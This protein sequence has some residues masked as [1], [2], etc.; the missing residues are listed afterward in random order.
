[1][2]T[3][4]TLLLAASALAAVAL[5]GPQLA[6]AQEAAAPVAEAV[7]IAAPAPDATITAIVTTVITAASAKFPWIVSALSIFAVVANVYQAVITFAHK[8]AAE[9]ADLKDDHWIATLEAKWWF[10]ILDRIFY[11][12]GYAGARF[13]GKKL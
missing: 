7:A 8:R 1:M 13:G 3:I 5:F 12:G 9:T 11:W 6:H 4:R 2:K 10:R